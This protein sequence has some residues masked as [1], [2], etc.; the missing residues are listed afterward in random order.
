MPDIDWEAE[1][2]IDHIIEKTAARGWTDRQVQ[3]DDFAEL[4][5][6]AR[7][8]DAQLTLIYEQYFLPERHE[9]EWLILYEIARAIVHSS[10]AG[11]VASSAVT[12]VIG[13][14]AFNLLKKMC[15]SAAS[16]FRTRLGPDAADRASGFEELAADSGKINNFLSKHSTARIEDIERETGIGRDRIH[17]LV[18]LAGLKHYRRGSNTCHWEMPQALSQIEAAPSDLET[19]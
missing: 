6:D 16:R 4:R 10:V 11:Y 7:F 17:P 5:M 2:N 9:F 15:L 12:G 14:T 18:K 3:I 8:S 19:K 1:R 13:G